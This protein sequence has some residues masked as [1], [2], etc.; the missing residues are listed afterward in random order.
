M[1]M[2][3]HDRHDGTNTRGNHLANV[4]LEEKHFRNV[5]KF[6]NIR[7]SWKEWRRQFLGAVRECDVAF[8]DFVE[9]FDTCEDPIDHI[10]SYTP[11]QN[12]LS[13]TMYNRLIG[14]TTGTAFQ[15]VESV[16]FYNGIEA[17]RLLNL[18]YDPKT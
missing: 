5:E 17:W 2:M 1:Q 6:N 13:T 10:S 18:Q 3:Q 7:S 15:I 16:P 9:T 4:R 8:A 12:L 11:T 14:F